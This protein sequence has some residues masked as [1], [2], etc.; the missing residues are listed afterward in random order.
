M[1]KA[2]N[3]TLAQSDAEDNSSQKTTSL[4]WSLARP[5]LANPKA[6]VFQK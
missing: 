5:K 4:F 2:G 1:Q 3:F 6:E